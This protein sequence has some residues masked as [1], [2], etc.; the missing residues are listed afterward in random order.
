MITAQTFEEQYARIHNQDIDVI[1]SLVPKKDVIGYYS[2]FADKR[3][4]EHLSLYR[5]RPAKPENVFAIEALHVGAD[6]DGITYTESELS[7]AAKTSSFRPI[8]V[9]HARKFKT[10]SNL[11][12]PQNQTLW[13]DYNPSL[14]AV[15]GHIQLDDHHSW[16][17][18]LDK[19]TSVS[20]EF[21]SLSNIEGQCMVFSGLSLVRD[22]RPADKKTRIYGGFQL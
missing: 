18:R 8:D 9:N 3:I 12:F 13:M 16:Q 21:Y 1:L 15:A 19:I 14:Q 5:E 2:K 10:G 6:S 20:V 22:A 17:V 11:P 7:R 4:T